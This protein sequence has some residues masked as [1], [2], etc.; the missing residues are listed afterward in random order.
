MELEKEKYAEKIKKEKED[1]TEDEKEDLEYIY[2]LEKYQ[3]VD[4]NFYQENI[5]LDLLI[6]NLNST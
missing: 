5:Q 3:I 4:I 6:A 2:N 1:K